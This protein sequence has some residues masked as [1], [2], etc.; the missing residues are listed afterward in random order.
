MQQRR[1][2]SDVRFDSGAAHQVLAGHGGGERVI[3]QIRLASRIS[4]HGIGQDGRGNH[5]H[6]D[7]VHFDKADLE[8][9][10]LDGLGAKPRG[11]GGAVADAENIRGEPGIDPDQVGERIRIR[12]HVLEQEK[13]SRQKVKGGRQKIDSR[14]KIINLFS[15]SAILLPAVSGECRQVG[16]KS[17]RRISIKRLV[18]AD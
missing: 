17:K 12:F 3:P 7:P 14:N 10:L 2:K 15:H 5:R 9:R 4:C 6:D 18:Q 1:G 11:V 8:D 13:Q 16:E